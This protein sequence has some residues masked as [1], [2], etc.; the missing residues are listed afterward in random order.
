MVRVKHRHLLIRFYPE[1]SDTA[2]APFSAVLPHHVAAYVRDAVAGLFGDPGQSAITAGA[3]SMPVS[4][5]PAGVPAGGK[6]PSL[7]Y[8]NPG[9]GRAIVRVAREAAAP[10]RAAITLA[11]P[12][13]ITSSNG[14]KVFCTPRVVHIGGTLKSLLQAGRE[15]LH[16]RRTLKSL[17]QAGREHLHLE[18]LAI[19]E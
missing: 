4:T 11:A 3:K 6:G 5:L 1:P 9:T 7:L 2:V 17:L 10:V 16:L 14:S 8:W 19:I 15:H 12:M 13:H 18:Q